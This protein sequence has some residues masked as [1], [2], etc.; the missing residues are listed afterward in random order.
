MLIH[1]VALDA[2]G[3]SGQTWASVS[4]SKAPEHCP[5]AAVYIKEKR[6][7]QAHALSREELVGGGVKDSMKRTASRTPKK[8][9]Q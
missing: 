3:P 1:P 8:S 9:P 5:P 7:L 2:S 6:N 4:G